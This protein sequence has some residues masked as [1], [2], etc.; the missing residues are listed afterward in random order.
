[1]KFVTDRDCPKCSFPE[2]IIE[3]LHNN[4]GGER[5]QRYCNKCGWHSKPSYRQITI[6]TKKGHNDGQ[7]KNN[8]KD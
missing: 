5:R 1:M 8:Y 3:V 2:T 7:R 6:S 4:M